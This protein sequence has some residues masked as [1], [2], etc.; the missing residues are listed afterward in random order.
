MEDKVFK[1]SVA[2]EPQDYE[3]VQKVARDRNLGRRGF[4]AAMRMIIR[5]WQQQQEKPHAPLS[6]DNNQEQT[7]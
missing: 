4:S 5:E 1:I 2:F 6:T 7:Q 3:T